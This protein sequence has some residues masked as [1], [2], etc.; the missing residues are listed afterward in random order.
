MVKEAIRHMP[1]VLIDTTT[2][3][4]YDKTRQAEAFE[5]LPIFDELRS[6]MTTGV[7]RERIRKEVKGFYQYVMLSHKWQPSEPTF[8]TVED[9]SVPHELQA[10]TFLR[11]RALS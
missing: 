10:A 9:T 7:D 11:A 2:G 1:R 4:L 5:E 6:S 8:Q 3:R